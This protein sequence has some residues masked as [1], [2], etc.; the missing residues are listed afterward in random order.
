[1]LPYNVAAAIKTRPRRD[2]LAQRILDEE[3]VAR[4]LD[5][6]EGRDRVLLKLLYVSG[7]RVSEI[8]GLR[9]RDLSPRREGGQ[10]TLFGKGG[11]TRTVLV[12][13]GTWTELTALRGAARD[14]EPVF[15]SRR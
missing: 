6:V 5:A 8:C 12:K 15:A 11:K 13:P 14:D 3:T 1:F 7:A 2:D 10:L 4:I 9:W